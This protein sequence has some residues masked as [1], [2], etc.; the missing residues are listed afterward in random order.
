MSDDL[1]NFLYT[2]PDKG[3]EIEGHICISN[4]CNTYE[5]RI[6]P[7]NIWT[8]DLT[9]QDGTIQKVE[10]SITSFLERSVCLNIDSQG[11]KIPFEISPKNCE[12]KENGSLVIDKND[13]N[14][15]LKI[16]IKKI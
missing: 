1:W 8:F 10:T 14:N 16:V 9:S 3:Y 7:N 12:I 11:K 2:M 13:L 4:Q 6:D 15:T 5:G